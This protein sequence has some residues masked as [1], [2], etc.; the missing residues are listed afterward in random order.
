MTHP[1]FLAE[2]A[3]KPNSVRGNSLRKAGNR[4]GWNLMTFPA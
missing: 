2:E 3:S 1:G 4:C